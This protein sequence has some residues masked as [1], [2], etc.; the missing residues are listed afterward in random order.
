M[1]GQSLG[2]VGPAMPGPARLGYLAICHPAGWGGPGFAGFLRE[3]GRG[4]STS[5][6]RIVRA[7]RDTP[8][9]SIRPRLCLWSQLESTQLWEPSLKPRN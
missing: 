3:S 6:R 5:A 7:A 8:R 2:P 9:L 1:V 4:V